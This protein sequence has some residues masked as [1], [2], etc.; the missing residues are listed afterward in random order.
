MSNNELN[1]LVSQIGNA[2]K[3]KFEK[4]RNKLF[5]VF[6]ILLLLVLCLSYFC[7]YTYKEITTL[8]VE[9][10]TEIE[11]LKTIN[12]PQKIDHYFIINDDKIKQINQ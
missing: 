3:E 11:F 4:L 10:T 1:L 12:T 7:Y 6:A 2:L 8:R 5:I 9:L